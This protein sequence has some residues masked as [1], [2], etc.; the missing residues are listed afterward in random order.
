[1]NLS[2]QMPSDLRLVIHPTIFEM[3]AW[4][5]QRCSSNPDIYLIAA[6]SRLDVPPDQVMG[7]QR[8]LMKVTL[9]SA[10]FGG[11][12]T[13]PVEPMSN[14]FSKY[15]TVLEQFRLAEDEECEQLLERLDFLYEQ[16]TEAEREAI[17][18]RPT[19]TPVS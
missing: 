9:M 13:R 12:R 2:P 7:W 17:E 10:F 1:M 11:P 15:L 18:A 3:K 4:F 19:Q 14:S 6:A 16:L 5:A 8:S